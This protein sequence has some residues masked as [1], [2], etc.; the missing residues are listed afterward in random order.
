M[1][2][3]R[4]VL[5]RAVELHAPFVQRSRHFEQSVRAD[6]RAGTGGER[7][8]PVAIG[9]RF[10]GEAT[11]ELRRTESATGVS[12]VGVCPRPAKLPEPAIECGT[13]IECSTLGRVGANA[14]RNFT[15]QTSIGRRT[16]G[17]D[18]DDPAERISAV[19]GRAR[20]AHDLYPFD[21][22]KRQILQ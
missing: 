21:E 1:A 8:V 3:L 14:G 4:D 7:G 18:L 16:A 12:T 9:V 20:S 22:L 2:E 10:V 11:D 15:L 17:K 6:L 5:E 19:Q 13:E